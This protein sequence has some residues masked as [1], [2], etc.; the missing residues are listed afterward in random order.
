M[1][2]SIAAI[3][4][5][6]LFSANTIAAQNDWNF[7]DLGYTSANYEDLDSN[8]DGFSIKGSYLVND[9]II[10]TADFQRLS[11]DLYGVDV[12]LDQLSVGA[13]YRF[14]LNDKTE[15][16]AILSYERIEAKAQYMGYSDDEDDN[17]YGLTAGI[18]QM[19]GE[20]VE[21]KVEAG[22]VNTSD[23]RE[24]SYTLGGR[25]Y[26]NDQWSVAFDYALASERNLTS[27][28]ARYQF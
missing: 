22:Y 14:V 2:K 3:A 8:P 6:T 10:L 24:M 19:V 25:Y 28:S 7:V 26:I 9:N 17:G 20:N 5:A 1:K 11:D 18:R 15:A 23:D 27:F 16:Y 12:D 4:L 21:L 13:G